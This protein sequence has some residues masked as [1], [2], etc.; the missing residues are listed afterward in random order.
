M[1]N[2]AQARGP[3]PAI[4]LPDLSSLLDVETPSSTPLDTRAA[5]LTPCARE[6]E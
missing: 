1:A 4:P 6:G 2:L 3:S 5:L